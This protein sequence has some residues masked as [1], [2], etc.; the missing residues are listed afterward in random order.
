MG[1]TIQDLHSEVVIM[2]QVVDS[3]AEMYGREEGYNG[4]GDEIALGNPLPHTLENKILTMYK[5][6]SRLFRDVRSLKDWETE[7]NKTADRLDI[8]FTYNIK[9][10]EEQFVKTYNEL[11]GIGLQERYW[12]EE[13]SSSYDEGYDEW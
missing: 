8:I 2:G 7:I 5:T 9:Y 3:V 12:D 11:V 10:L 1:N 13:E 4:D 6:K